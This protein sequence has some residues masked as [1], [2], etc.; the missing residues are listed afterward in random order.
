MQRPQAPAWQASPWGHRPSSSA[1]CAVPMRLSRINRHIKDKHCAKQRALLGVL[2]SRFSSVSRDIRSTYPFWIGSPLVHTAVL[3]LVIRTW[4]YFATTRSASV[5]SWDRVATSAALPLGK[6]GKHQRSNVAPSNLY[7]TIVKLNCATL[8]LYI[9]A[10]IAP[11][12][13]EVCFIG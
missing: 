2:S 10:S 13:V 8:L 3:N 6:G 5:G 9:S 7:C 4:F 12:Y 1:P 11:L